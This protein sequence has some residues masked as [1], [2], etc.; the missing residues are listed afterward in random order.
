MEAVLFILLIQ[1]LVFGFFCS[2]IAREKNRD[3]A[4][5][6][7]L[8]FCFSILAVFALIAIPKADRIRSNPGPQP[9]SESP[10][11]RELIDDSYRIW[12]VKKYDIIK[13]DVLNSFVCN[14]KLFTT[15]D[16]ALNHAHQLEQAAVAKEILKAEVF[17]TERISQETARLAEIANDKKKL[18]YVVIMIFVFLVAASGVEI[19][20]LIV[21][22]NVINEKLAELNSSTK[23]LGVYPGSTA[24]V[25]NPETGGCKYAGG[26]KGNSK[27]LRFSSYDKLESID[28]YYAEKMKSSG[29]TQTKKFGLENKNYTSEYSLMDG[30]KNVLLSIES[31]IDKINVCYMVTREGN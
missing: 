9:S 3:G 13:N 15:I 25:F 16:E 27:M 5:W 26:V 23:P 8:G 29:Y 4:S 24:I 14:N 21:D 2:Y 6:F 11:N 7:L 30:G 17:E 10:S 20:K 18:R 19:N 12:L 1:G 31:D 22:A 28:D